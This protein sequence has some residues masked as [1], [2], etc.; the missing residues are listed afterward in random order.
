[1]RLAL[2]S[3]DTDMHSGKLLSMSDVEGWHAEAWPLVQ[4]EWGEA[5]TQ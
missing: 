4:I 2:Y 1:L 5:A 3:A